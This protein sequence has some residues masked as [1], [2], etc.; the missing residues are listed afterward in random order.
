MS[1]SRR[2]RLLLGLYPREWRAR[3]GPELDE[4]ISQTS[5]GHGPG[6]R[7]TADLVASAV[8]ERLHAAGLAGDVPPGER[9][10]GGALLVLWS[11]LLFVLA[12]L[13]LQKLSEHWQASLSSTGRAYSSTAFDVLVVTAPLAS[14]LVL[15]A[16]ATALPSLVSFLRA[17]GWTQLRRPVVTS[18]AITAC[19][20]AAT[21]ALVAWADGLSE[22][23]RNGHDLAYAAG[24]LGWALVVAACLTS[25]TAT[26]AA[27]LRRIDLSAGRLRLDAWIA[28]G[29]TA[30]MALMSALTIVWWA[31]LPARA[32]MA[33][34]DARLALTVALMLA[35]SSLGA[36]GAARALRASPRLTERG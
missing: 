18:V 10:R 34:A 27:V 21:I 22:G 12:G 28:A 35:A 13:S 33:G 5:G 6:P 25:W 24:F 8:R 9:V 20:L 16:A 3:Y 30:A 23:Q 1:A 32:P 29:V 15:V 7:A 14:A 36:I 26:A 4:L 2:T 31:E 11:W 17:G 19:A